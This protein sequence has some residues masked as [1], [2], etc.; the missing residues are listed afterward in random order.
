MVELLRP[1]EKLFRK[2]AGIGVRYRALMIDMT[3]AS[4]GGLEFALIF[5]RPF[6]IYY[7]K[8]LAASAD[9]EMIQMMGGLTQIYGIF[10]ALIIGTLLFLIAIACVEGGWGTSPGKYFLKIRIFDE[11]GRP[12]ET[13]TLILRAVIKNLGT[14]LSI[15]AIPTKSLFIAVFSTIVC[16]VMGVGYTMAFG[17]RRQTLHDRIAETAVYPVTSNFEA[18]EI[19]SKQ[20]ELL[21]GIQNIEEKNISASAGITSN[22]L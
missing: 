2:R 14:L 20:D 15:L 6:Q 12:A 18:A 22:K 21:S 13:S 1:Q 4:V 7:Q 5:F 8:K 9:Q 3:L 16:L 19:L 10:F 17:K 11:S